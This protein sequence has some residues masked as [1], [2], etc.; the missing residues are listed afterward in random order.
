MLLS[1]PTELLLRLALLLDI[2]DLVDLSRTCKTLHTILTSVYFRKLCWNK[3]AN[4]VAF[5]VWHASIWI[6]RELDS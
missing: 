1:L 4:S 3:A 2:P 6:A 5:T